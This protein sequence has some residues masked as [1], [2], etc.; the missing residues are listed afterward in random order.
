MG[1]AQRALIPNSELVILDDAP[2][3]ISSVPAAHA[4]FGELAVDFFK[5]H[6]LSGR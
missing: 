2:H 1:Y 3:A 6:P 4:R 5:R